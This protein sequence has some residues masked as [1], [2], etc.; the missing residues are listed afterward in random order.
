[1]SRKWKVFWIVVAALAAAGIFLTAAGIVM[2]GLTDLSSREDE[3]IVSSWLNR[4]GLGSS[5]STIAMSDGGDIAN[6]GDPDSGYVPGEPN[7]TTVTAYE[8]ISEMDFDIA[9][10]GLSVQAYDGEKIIVDISELREDL[11]DD[12]AVFREDEKLKV[13]MESHG[14]WNTNDTGLIR[15]SVPA[16]ASFEK[17]SAH[18]GAGFIQMDALDASEISVDVGAGQGILTSF[19]ADIL[20]ADCG[21]GQIILEGEVYD[22]A[23]ISCN[24]G[25]V[26]Y[27]VPGE[28]ETYDYEVTCGIGEVVIGSEAYSGL[29][30]KLE[31]DNGSGTGIRVDCGLGRIEIIFE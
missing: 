4:L 6:D 18:A 28:P 25:E 1:M 26:L 14:K 7:G 17:V 15:V 27:T 23:D 2:G 12:V 3:R 30:D 11:Q 13:E 8:D 10:A 16:D 22:E 24:I 5:E 19:Y 9:A 31:I 29:N 21:A 20:E